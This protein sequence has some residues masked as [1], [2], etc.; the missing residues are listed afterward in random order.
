MKYCPKCGKSL[1]D[2]ASFCLEC[3]EDV[4]A[5]NPAVVVAEKET[6][7]RLNILAIIGAALCFMGLPG[8]II[9]GIA[10]KNATY[11]KYRVPLR[12]AAIA[13]LVVGIFFTIFW[14]VYIAC[15]CTALGFVFT[16]VIQELSDHVW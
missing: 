10:L 9:S 7:P 8:A 6:R 11:D 1:P 5:V 4:R 14:A 3:G 2:D 13:G 15:V 12:P 16:R